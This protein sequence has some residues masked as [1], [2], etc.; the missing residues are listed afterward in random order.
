VG[1]LRNAYI[2]VGKPDG[3]RPL[4]RLKCRWKDIRMDVRELRWES[5]DWIHVAQD[6]NQ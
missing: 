1:Q 2:S 6:R 5:V 4:R 3:K